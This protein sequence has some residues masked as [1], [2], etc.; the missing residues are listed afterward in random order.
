VKERVCVGERER[1]CV[2]VCADSSPHLPKR[3]DDMQVRESVCE[4]EA[5]PFTAVHAYN[6]LNN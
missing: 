5:M 2:F 4:C 3:V 6:N 1:V